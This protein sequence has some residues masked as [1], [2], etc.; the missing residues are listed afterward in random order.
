MLRAHTASQDDRKSALLA[1]N[2]ISKA[3]MLVNPVLPEHI[4]VILDQANVC[5]ANQE[6]FAFTMARVSLTNASL[7]THADMEA[8]LRRLSH[9]LPALIVK[10]PWLP[11]LV[12]RPCNPREDHVSVE[13]KLTVW[14]AYT[15]Q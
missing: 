10:L 9:V 13:Q 4:R 14:L 7:V 1:S 5:C 8:R 2:A 6:H 15:R 3:Y 11:I 12:P